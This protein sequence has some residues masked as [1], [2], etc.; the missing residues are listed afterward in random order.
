M[1]YPII[2]IILKFLPP[3][4]VK[5]NVT[6]DDIR[7]K[8]NIK[9]IQTLIFI[10]KV[11][12]Y[13]ILVFTQSHYYPSVMSMWLP[14]KMSFWDRQFTYLVCNTVSSLIIYI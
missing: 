12:F 14:V 11:F 1:K 6:I 4:E 3:D 13:A 8:S 9:I 5:V 10:K 2:K 7:L